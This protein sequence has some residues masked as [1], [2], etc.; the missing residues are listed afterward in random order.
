MGLALTN[1]RRSIS[2]FDIEPNQKTG[3]AKRPVD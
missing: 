3:P 2:V 1:I